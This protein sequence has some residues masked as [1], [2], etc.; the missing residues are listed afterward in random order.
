M[1]LITERIKPETN[2]LLSRQLEV[3]LEAGDMLKNDF[4]N[5]LK[6]V[7]LSCQ[8]I[9][10]LLNELQ[11]P[12]LKPRC[13]DLTDAGP[14]VIGVTNYEVKFRD[15]EIW[16]MFDSYYRDTCSQNH[17]ETVDRVRLREQ[18]LPSEMLLLVDLYHWVGEV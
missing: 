15:A 13:C 1:K 3:C 2:I 16:R 6:S 7:L 18:T 10:T 17:G 9:I 12:K 8:R 14:G 11:L 5:S 4:E